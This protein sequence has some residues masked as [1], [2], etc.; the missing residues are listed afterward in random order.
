MTTASFVVFGPEHLAVLGL[1]VAAA[2][3]MIWAARLNNWPRLVRFQ[4]W[5][6]IAVLILSWPADWVSAYA[7]NAVTWE[8]ILPLHLCDLASFAGVIALVWRHQLAA[9]LAYFWAMAGTLNGLITPAITASFPHPIFIAFFMLHGAVVVTAIYLIGGLRLWPRPGAVWRTF[10][11]SLVYLM[12]ITGINALLGTNFAFVC[13]KPDTP[14]LMDAL[15]PWPWYVLWLIPLG[16]VLYTVFYFP[17]W[18]AHKRGWT[19]RLTSLSKPTTPPIITMAT[20]KE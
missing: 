5:I 15:G 4:E 10:A 9:E 11:A 19:S 8:T 7:T 13:R 12:A 1:V 16:L 18:L 17:F 14:S 6:L 2:S 20:S 3:G